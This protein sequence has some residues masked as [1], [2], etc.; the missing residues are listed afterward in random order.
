L[1]RRYAWSGLSLGVFSALMFA[2]CCLHRSCFSLTISI[3]FPR[4]SHFL[5]QIS[6]LCLIYGDVWKKAV[7][8]LF[9]DQS[10]NRVPTIRASKTM[11][12]IS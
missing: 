10:W 2:F 11:C 9:S 12:L 7:W 8:R 4:N 6:V 5:V 1:N 3:P